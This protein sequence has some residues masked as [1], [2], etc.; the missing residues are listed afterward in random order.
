MI[1]T[2]DIDIDT[3]DRNKLLNCIKNTPAMINDKNREKK[4]NTGVY[5]HEVPENP[6]SG[7]C[8]IDHKEAENIGYFKMDILNVSVY[9][10]I[11][12]NTEMDELL[13][14]DI[15]WELFEHEDIVKRLFH[16]H[17]HYEVVRRMRPQSIGQLAAVLGVIRPAKRHLLG[18]DWNIVLA[19][20][21]KKP[22]NDEGYFFKKAHAHAYAMAIVVQ[23]NKIVKDSFS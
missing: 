11:E 20:V 22:S 18:K 4:H 7:L 8:T 21:W 16:I 23:L 2:T 6:F 17:S 14:M 9:D 12:S 13:Q 19:E 15:M 5:F 10:G 1:T 3:A